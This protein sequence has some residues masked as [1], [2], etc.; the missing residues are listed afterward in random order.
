MRSPS[1]KQTSRKGNSQ[2][3]RGSQGQDYNV[4][5]TRLS[6][7]VGK[8]EGISQMTDDLSFSSFFFFVAHKQTG[9]ST[10]ATHTLCISEAR[11]ACSWSLC[12]TPRGKEMMN[13]CKIVDPTANMIFYSPFFF[14]FLTGCSPTAPTSSPA[15]LRRRSS[16][17]TGCRTETLPQHKRPK[18]ETKTHSV[19]YENSPTQKYA[20][21]LN[22][23]W[24]VRSGLCT[25]CPGP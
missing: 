20:V 8:P 13:C 6:L 14:L 16:V 11:V 12:F 19:S 24:N 7:S 3:Q 15:V 18:W 25:D 1:N 5:Q 23:Q 10:Y 4:C 9:F 22:V 2:L 21:V 17:F